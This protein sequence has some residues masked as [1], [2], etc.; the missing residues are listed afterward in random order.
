MTEKKRKRKI[1]FI[2]LYLRKK[3]KYENI[4]EYFLEKF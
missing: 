4:S 1:L 2:F 3:I